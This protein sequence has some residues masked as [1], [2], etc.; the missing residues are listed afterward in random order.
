MIVAIHQPSYFSWLGLI[1]KIA[2]ADIFIL[3]DEV[4]LADRAF[5]HR[6]IFLDASGNQ[7]YLTIPIIKKNL[8]QKVIREIE[9][10]NTVNWKRKH[11]NFL[12]FNY[13][14]H[15]YFSEIFPVVE[16]YFKKDYKTLLQA[17]W[18]SMKLILNFFDIKTKVIFQS[19]ISYDR[20]KRKGELML[21]LVKAVGGKVY[22]SGVGAKGYLEP[23]L[24][25][26]EVEGI[27]V[28][29]NNFKHFKYPQRN[30]KGVFIEGLS[31]LDLLFNVGIKKA[32]DM[33]WNCVIEEKK[34]LFTER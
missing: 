20:T 10:N 25:K 11:L 6:N 2:K 32:K 12:F 21:S 33:F 27:K 26:F 30:S 3:L 31:S 4:Q 17:V 16:D 7:K 8:R 23:I 28:I 9:I 1:N 34:K 22:L 13:K 5:Q 29:W 19:Q 15:P 14:K 18:E 24:D